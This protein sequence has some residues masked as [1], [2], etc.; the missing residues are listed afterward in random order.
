MKDVAERTGK[1]AAMHQQVTSYVT[2]PSLTLT[3]ALQHSVGHWQR[4][5][6]TTRNSNKTM[7]LWTIT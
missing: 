7:S 5:S 2:G 1:V 3:P 4:A 6:I